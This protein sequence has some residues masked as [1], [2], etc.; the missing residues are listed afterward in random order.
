MRIIIRAVGY[1]EVRQ[2]VGLVACDP[3]GRSSTSP[4]AP[5]ASVVVRIC[6]PPVSAQPVPSKSS[7][8]SPGASAY[9]L[10]SPQARNGWDSAGSVQLEVSTDVVMAVSVL[11]GAV[12]AAAA[13]GAAPRVRAATPSPMQR[14]RL[15]PHVPTFR[16][17]LPAGARPTSLWTS[18][19]GAVPVGRFSIVI[20]RAA[21]M[22]ERRR[23]VRHLFG[24]RMIV[25][26]AAI[27]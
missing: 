6:A 1:A 2:I 27:R 17:C 24:I 15:L 3:R 10:L 16:G 7:A 11:A 19:S 4:V 23:E 13:A 22:F 20:V 18:G 9:Q 12:L 25:R 5:S 26:R 21:G 8:A 14:N